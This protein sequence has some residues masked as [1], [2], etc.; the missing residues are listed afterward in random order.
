MERSTTT[1]PVTQI[2]EDARIARDTLDRALQ[3]MIV[4]E[5][6]GATGV[7]VHLAGLVETTGTVLSDATMSSLGAIGNVSELTVLSVL[8]V[9]YLWHFG[10]KKIRSYSQD[11]AA[12]VNVLLVGLLALLFAAIHY[13]TLMRSQLSPYSVIAVLLGILQTGRFACYTEFA[14]GAW[15]ADAVIARVNATEQEKTE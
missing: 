1:T 4:L 9:A 7:I 11:L 13:H 6:C 14:L 2:R 5:L 15:K 3:H 8:F 12:V 10:A